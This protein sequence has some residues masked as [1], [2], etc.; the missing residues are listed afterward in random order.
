MADLNFALV[1]Y[2]NCTIKVHFYKAR[3]YN[4]QRAG[5]QTLEK[6]Q[7]NIKRKRNK[8]KSYIGDN[9]LIIRIYKIRYTYDCRQKKGKKVKPN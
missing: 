8:Y 1:G 6:G 7:T 4:C 2:N 5:V 3:I 9:F